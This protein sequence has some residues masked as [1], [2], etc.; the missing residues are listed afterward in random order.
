MRLKLETVPLDKSAFF[1]G[2][3]TF[4]D[5]R[6]KRVPYESQHIYPVWLE[7]DSFCDV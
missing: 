7:I 6:Q 3:W 1:L 5:D 4:S 2:A